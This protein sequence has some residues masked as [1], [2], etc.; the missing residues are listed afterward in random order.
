M[1]VRQAKDYEFR[2]FFITLRKFTK[3]HQKSDMKKSAQYLADIYRCTA[4]SRQPVLQFINSHSFADRNTT[5]IVVNLIRRMSGIQQSARAEH[6][7]WIAIHL[8]CANTVMVWSVHWNLPTF[9][10]FSGFPF[11]HAV[12]LTT[13]FM[14]MFTPARMMISN[15]V[16]VFCG[17]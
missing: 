10:R 1:D 7:Q 12:T 8:D 11:G 5:Y 2:L 15:V 6:S 3:Q 16:L 9:D 4:N 17:H 13:P 14:E